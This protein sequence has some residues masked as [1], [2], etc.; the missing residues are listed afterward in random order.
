MFP[1]FTL[2]I[3][4]LFTAYVL[5]SIH[6]IYVL[7]N[8]Q[9]C[10]QKRDLCLN[11]SFT[12]NDIFELYLCTSVDEHPLAKK[13]NCFYENKKFSLQTENTLS[14]GVSLPSYTLNNGSL[15]LH[16]VLT[17]LKNFREVDRYVITHKSTS[18][19]ST[20]LTKYTPK[21]A[22]AFNLLNKGIYDEEKETT[23]QK[24]SERPI[25][26]WKPKLVLNIVSTPLALSR[27]ALPGEIAHLLKL[28]EKKEYLPIVYISEVRQRIKDL[29]PVNQ[30]YPEMPLEVVYEP[31]TIGKLRFMLIIESSLK[32]MNKMGFTDNDTDDV[33]GIFFDTHIYLLL[34]TVFVTSFHVLFD[35]LAFKND[36]QFW[37]SRKSMEGLSFSTLLWRCVSQFVITLYL[38]DQKTSYLVLIPSAIGTVIEFW[39]LKKALKIEIIGWKFTIRNRTEAEKQTDAYDSKFMKYLSLYILTPLVIG[40]AIYS[41]LYTEHKSWYSWLIQSAA[42]GVYAF[43]F[44]FMLPQLFINYKLKSV[45]HLPWRAFMYKAFNTFIDDLF[46][47]LITSLP[48]AHRVAAFRDDIVFIIYLYQRWLYPVDKTRVNEFG[49]TAEEK[50]TK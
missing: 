27:R 21:Q 17:S 32:S 18:L 10:D 19:A 4:G 7:Y 44:L 8:P 2:I 50:K 34:L 37:R 5:H 28:T 45:A 22:K 14:F 33:K 35:F 25:T 48:T 24:G 43:G 46:A 15:Y 12:T 13:L 6:T 11:P 1:S 36:I 20:P 40:G 29:W 23:N 31:T 49:E 9:E 42:N 30:S 26:H 16:T 3:S 41:I 47:F 38:M 39:K